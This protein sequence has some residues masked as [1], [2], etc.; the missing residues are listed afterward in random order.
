LTCPRKFGFKYLAEEREPQNY[1]MERGSSVHE[2]FELFHQDLIDVI[3]SG[4]GVPDR[5]TPMLRES[6]KWFQFME[7]IGPF[8]EW[9][10]ERLEA[11]RKEAE[12]ADEAIRLWKPHSVEEE[13]YVEE[14]PVGEVPWLGPYDALV[15]SESVPQIDSGEGYVVIDYKTGSL[16]DEQYRDTGIHIDLEFYAWMLEESGFEVAGGVGLYPTEDSNIVREMP[17]EETRETIEDVINY[18]HAADPTI[19]D[20]PIDPQPLCDWCFYQEQCPTTWG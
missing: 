8:F 3:E 15:H 11:A 16:K 14:P 12:S 18:L 20:F 17:N 5:F 2:T 4:S 1:Y 10:L 9:E 13:L 7:Y 19:E 6:D